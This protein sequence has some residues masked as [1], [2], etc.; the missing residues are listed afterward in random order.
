MYIEENKLPSQ[1]FKVAELTIG[2][3]KLLAGKKISEESIMTF[4]EI[5]L[6]YDKRYE[7]IRDFYFSQNF[8]DLK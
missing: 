1:T 3:C 7:F 6:G 8:S 5:I 4:N 2:W